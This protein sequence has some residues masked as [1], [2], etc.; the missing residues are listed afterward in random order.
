M[1]IG[2]P[3]QVRRVEPGHAVCDG[4]GEQRRVRTALVGEVALGDW[5]LIFIDSA[6]QRLSAQR[7]A[8]IDAVLDLVQDALAGQAACPDAAAAPAFELPSR[9]TVRQMQVLSGA[10]PPSDHE[11]PS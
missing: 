5:L 8:E 9:M 6:Q 4:R 2:I 3:M 7:A 10:R 11:S 1:C